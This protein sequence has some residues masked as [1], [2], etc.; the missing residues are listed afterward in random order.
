MIHCSS[1]HCGRSTVVVFAV[2]VV[3]AAMVVLVAVSSGVGRGWRTNCCTC[4]RSICEYLCNSGTRSR[5]NGDAFS[6]SDSSNS[7]SH[8]G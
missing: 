1:T 6:G 8:W 5:S 7:S 4:A 3:V 2:V